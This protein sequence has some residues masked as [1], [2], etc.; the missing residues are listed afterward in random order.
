M[1]TPKINEWFEYS[2]SAALWVSMILLAY[3]V[4]AKDRSG[5][6]CSIVGYTL[7]GFSILLFM[8]NLIYK[9]YKGSTDMINNIFTLLPF[10]ITLGSI[11]FM[12][13]IIYSYTDRISSDNVSPGYYTFSKIFLVLNALQLLAFNMLTNNYNTQEDNYRQTKLSQSLAFLIFSIFIILDIITIYII[14]TFFTTDG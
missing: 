1:P 9:M 10:V 3:S 4:D 13:Y 14:L 12:I 8:L 7:L 5:L 11:G 2:S 6:T